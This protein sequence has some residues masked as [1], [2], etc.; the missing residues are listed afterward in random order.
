MYKWWLWE[1]IEKFIEFDQH[2]V[3]S[4]KNKENMWYWCVNYLNGRILNVVEI[5]EHLLCNGFLKNYTT[6]I[7]HGELV[8]TPGVAETHEYVLDNGQ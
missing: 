2:H 5:R 4:V 6:W 3:G 1:R 7:W 8:N